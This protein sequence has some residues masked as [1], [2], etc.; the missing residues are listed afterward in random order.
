MKK[1]ILIICLITTFGCE[2]IIEVDV[3]NNNKVLVLNSIINTDSTFRV[4]VSETVGILRPTESIQGVDDATISLYEEDNFIEELIFDA[5]RFYYVTED[6]KPKSNT[7]YRIELE[8]NSFEKVVANTSIPS[9]PPEIK[10]FTVDS[11]F[12][13][14]FKSFEFDLT[15][16]DPNQENFYEVKIFA[17]FYNREFDPDTDTYKIVDSTLFDLNISTNDQSVEEYFDYDKIIFNDKLFNGKEFSI[18]F[19]SSIGFSDNLSDNI[20]QIVVEFR[21]INEDYFEYE[22][23][24]GLQRWVDDDPFAEPVPVYNN[25]ENGYGIFG[26]FTNRYLSVNWKD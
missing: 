19:Q 10:K 7:N 4:D 21:H 5:E 20:G 24:T 12:E 14:G 13:N 9:L 17:Y 3:E 18:R 2:T 8:A 22:R 16:K 1:Y 6:F 15:F 25:I 26:G 11:S 23:T